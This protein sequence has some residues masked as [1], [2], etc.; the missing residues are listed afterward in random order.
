M[1]NK[2]PILVSGSHRS[3][4]TWVG[5]MLA[6][7][8]SVGYI[9]EPFNL[10]HRQHHPGIC[11][12]KFDYWFTY[13]TDENESIFYKDIKDTIN[14]SYK[15]KEE[16]QAINSLKETG[17]MLLDYFNFSRY[18]LANARPLVKDPIAIF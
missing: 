15:L 17:R 18:R 16:L 2:K 9:N 13:I 8:P 3:G 7:C 12:A 4:S 10:G 6:L 5:K 11:S 1:I 14:F